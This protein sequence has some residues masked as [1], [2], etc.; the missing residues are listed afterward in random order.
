MIFDIL[1]LKLQW[2]IHMP[3]GD[4]F[5]SQRDTPSLEFLGQIHT[6]LV[7]LASQIHTKER[8]LVTYQIGQTWRLW[9][10]ADTCNS[11]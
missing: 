2:Q 11:H 6:A 3:F 7:V 9:K 8:D 10:T 5:Q 1:L 4:C